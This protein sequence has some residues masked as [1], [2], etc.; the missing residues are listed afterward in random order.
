[1]TPVDS[2]RY[3]RYLNLV[4][5][6]QESAYTSALQGTLEAGMAAGWLDAMAA[7]T[8]RPG[9]DEYWRRGRLGYQPAFRAAMDSVFAV[10]DC[11]K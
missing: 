7:L 1:M 10:A 2:L 9:M 8:C 5:N 4:M 11:S 3:N 6:V